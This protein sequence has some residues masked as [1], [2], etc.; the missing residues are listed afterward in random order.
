LLK[1]PVT[2]A[3]AS[4]SSLSYGEGSTYLDSLALS[5]SWFNGISSF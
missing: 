4:G 2:G 5:W 3:D 1:F